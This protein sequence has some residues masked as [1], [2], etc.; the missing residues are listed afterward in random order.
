MESDY[1]K[2]AKKAIEEI[3]GLAKVYIGTE[4][5][6]APENTLKDFKPGIATF[7]WFSPIEI[8][9]DK[10]QKQVDE[11]L[12]D[13]TTDMNSMFWLDYPSYPFPFDAE[14]TVTKK[15]L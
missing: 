15:V 10:V 14:V 1:R 12:K 7:H 2:L 6:N 3:Q 8:D 9:T 11:F 13:N 4:T 5:P